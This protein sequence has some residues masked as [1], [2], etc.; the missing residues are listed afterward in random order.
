M[1]QWRNEYT[2]RLKRC[3]VTIN[4]WPFAGPELLL[5]GRAGP[6]VCELGVILHWRNE[7]EKRPPCYKV[8]GDWALFWA[9]VAAAAKGRA[10]CLWGGLGVPLADSAGGVGVPLAELAQKAPQGE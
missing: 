10:W 7:Y 6:D 5:R 4:S 9:A 8:A 2:E 1:F 3:E